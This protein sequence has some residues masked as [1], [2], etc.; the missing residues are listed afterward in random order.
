MATAS[1]SKLHFTAIDHLNSYPAI[2][3]IK[4]F[5]LSWSVSSLIFNSI[6]TYI[7]NL[8]SF[9]SQFEIFISY[10]NYLDSL[11]NSTFSLIDS[12][13]SF[14]KNFSFISTYKSLIK[15]FND[16]LNSLL[17]VTRQ[18]FNNFI[19][20]FDPILKISNDYYES[21]L[22]L[23]FPTSAFTDF[24]TKLKII[25]NEQ[26]QF[27][28][29]L[30]LLDET[31]NRINLT[32]TTVSKIPSHVSNVYQNELKETKSTT[33]AVSK[34]T[35]KLSNDAFQTIKPTFEKVSKAVNLTN[36]NI[37]SN[38]DKVTE[39]LIEIKDNIQNEFSNVTGV[40]V[41]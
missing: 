40:E 17:N 3:E 13:F 21:L 10:W 22:N 30:N 35:R 1:Y 11:L 41:H 24:K 34:T 29:L 25:T 6:S 4:S 2:D 8:L 14:I 5:I 20:Y 31:F 33:Q 23:I 19:K 9:L 28:R 39:P 27:Q 15:L 18:P 36:N 7:K 16:N 32:V 38:I 26:N 12:R 37:N